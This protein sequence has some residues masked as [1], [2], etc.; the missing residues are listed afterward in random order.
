MKTFL[1]IAAPL[2]V[3]VGIAFAPKPAHA[4]GPVGIEVGGKVGMATNPSGGTNA[5]GLGVGGRGGVSV[6]NIYLGFNIVDYLGSS[7]NVPGLSSSAS[8]LQYG[9]ELGYSIKLVDIITIRP[10]VGLGNM[11]FSQSGNV[12]GISYSLNPSSFY[13][14]PGV[15]G[16]ITLGWFFFGADVNALIIPNYPGGTSSSGNGT[17]PTSSSST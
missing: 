2:A 8:A 3:A 14:E 4:L 17:A 5:L 1:R 10:Q 13:V 9:G 12:V 7:S 11:A 16:L 15:T 6:F